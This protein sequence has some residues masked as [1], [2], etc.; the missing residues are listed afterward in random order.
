MPDFQGKSRRARRQRS[1]QKRALDRP[2]VH[3]HRDPR[4][5]L[6]GDVP[7]PIEHPA[8]PEVGGLPFRVLRIERGPAGVRYALIGEF[9]TSIEATVLCNRERWRAIVDHWRGGRVH[10]NWREAKPPEK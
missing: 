2:V 5:D 10:D 3:H 7:V 9:D 4:A 8:I 6:V 1:Q